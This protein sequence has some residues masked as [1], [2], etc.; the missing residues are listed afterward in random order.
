MTT[1]QIAEEYVRLALDIDQHLPG[2]I[3][4]Y[5]GPPEWKDEAARAG[6]RPLVDL[7]HRAE[8]L[9]G[10]VAADDNLDPQRK[11]FLSLHVRAMQT[12]LRLLGG[13]KLS[14]A[15]E[16]ENIYDIRP[17]WID[18]SVFLERQRLLDD[19]LPRGGTLIERTA[20]RKR[21]VEIAV[22]K[23]K[24]LLPILE[25]RLRQAT[26]QRFPLPA[27]ESVEF[28]FVSGKP[29]QG[30]N[31][32]LGNCRSRI[33]LNT[34]LPMQLPRLVQLV[35]HECYPG[36]HT[37]LC[38]KDTRLHHEKGELEHSLAL[39][40][41]PTCAISEGIATSAFSVILSEQEQ[42]DWYVQEIFPRAGL[43]AELGERETAINAALF[44]L[45]AAAGNAAFMLHD[46]GA[47]DDEVLSYLRQ[48]G[49][50]T[51]AE[52]RKRLEFIRDP[53]DRSY[54]FTYDMG[55]QLLM[56]LFALKGDTTHWF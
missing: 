29:W 46:R 2:Y 8:I 55:R 26:R 22:E 44:P 4:A 16:V 41:S 30:Y 10:E 15:D 36:H 17:Q 11:D 21:S 14:L 56:S 53:L 50:L 1:Q 7:A 27:E 45:G 18:E 37:E 6:K 24:E 42:H 47:T 38:I 43:T 51:E 35:A 5:F 23:A 52:A 9:A 49:L 40:N 3:D 28:R 13:E 32:Y 54:V 25:A 48:Y 20:M 34:D 33:E 39:L 19:L 31:W 12:S